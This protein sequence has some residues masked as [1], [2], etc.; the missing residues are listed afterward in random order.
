MNKSIDKGRIAQRFRAA[1]PT[2][3][4]EAHVQTLIARDLCGYMLKQG[5]PLQYDKALEIGCGTGVMTKELVQ[6][7]NMKNLT[8]NDLD[9]SCPINQDVWSRLPQSTFYL[10][11]DAEVIDLGAP[12][13]LICSASTIQWFHDPRGFFSRIEKSL[14]SD[15]VIAISTFG[16][17]NLHEVRQLTG[18]GLTYYSID[19][20]RSWLAS[21]YEDILV[22]EAH[23]TLLF[24]DGME[25]L[26]HLKKTGVGAAPG[27]TEKWTPGRLKQFCNDYKAI[28]ETEDGY[29]PL[30]YHPIYI[31][32]RKKVSV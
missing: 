29:L 3:D 21:A 17:D 31:V 5:F 23:E 8:L 19:D 26:L 7:F 15:G 1:R 10:S 22:V 14:S 30:T 12:Y 20:I 27:P 13:N 28:F 9:S 24:K 4:N 25:A 6:R 2:Y 16:N 32:A 11:G 18:H